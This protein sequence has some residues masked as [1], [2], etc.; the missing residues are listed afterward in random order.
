MRVLVCG[1]R[2]FED[3]D[4]LNRTLDGLLTKGE[5]HTIIHGMARGADTMAENYARSRGYPLLEYPALWNTYGRA[6]GIIRNTE[7]LTEGKPEL[8]VAFLGRVAQKEFESG[9]SDSK[10][11]RGTK[12][13]IDQAT[14]SGV[15]VEIIDV[16]LSKEIYQ[17][18]P[19]SLGDVGRLARMALR[20]PEKPAGALK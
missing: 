9:L 19:I 2:T 13:M 15:P 20:L 5:S 11:S 1:S 10:Y 3:Q 6:A 17:L 4:L 14:T 16:D 8:V 7:M 12:N 18:K